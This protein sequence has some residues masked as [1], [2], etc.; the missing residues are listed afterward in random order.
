MTPFARHG[1]QRTNDLEMPVP[2]LGGTEEELERAEEVLQKFRPEQ[3][4]SELLPTL[5]P[6][7]NL[8]R[9]GHAVRKKLSLLL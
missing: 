1:H 3:N 7:L 9:A 8:S 6:N 4:L 2:R 5:Q